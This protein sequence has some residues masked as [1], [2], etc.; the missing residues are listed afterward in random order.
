MTNNVLSFDRLDEALPMP[1][2]PRAQ[3]ALKLAPV[4]DDLDRY[5]LQI[6]GLA[7]GN[8]EMSID[9]EVVAKINAD[10]LAA[11]CNLA[12]TAGPITK[13]SQALLDLVFEKNNLFYKRWRNG[14]RTANGSADDA[15]RDAEVAR[16]DSQITEAEAKINATRRPVSHHFELKRVTE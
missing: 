1:I 14:I 9:G 16:L 11:S 5:E 3:S 12:T 10:A 8:Y 4:L 15:A 7:A 13:Q 2:D 6:T